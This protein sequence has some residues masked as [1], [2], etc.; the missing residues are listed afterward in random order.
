MMREDALLLSVFGSLHTRL[1]SVPPPQRRKQPAL[2]QL[3]VDIRSDREKG[4]ILTA[5]VLYL[6]PKK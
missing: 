5:Y 3:I 4:N 1:P 2:F 6:N